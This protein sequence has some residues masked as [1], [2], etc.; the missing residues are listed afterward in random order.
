MLWPPNSPDLNPVDYKVWSVVQ[1]KVC[2]GRIK[3]VDNLHSCI[4]TAWDEL[5]RRIIEVAVRQWSMQLC[6]HV[7]MKG[8]HFEHKLS[9]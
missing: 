1:E 6:A 4:L 9:Q 5:D 7:K 3:N 8:A 2:K